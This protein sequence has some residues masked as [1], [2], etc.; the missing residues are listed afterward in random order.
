[1]YTEYNFNARKTERKFQRE[2]AKKGYFRTVKGFINKLVIYGKTHLT[3]Q[4]EKGTKPL[5]IARKSLR[6]AL[7]YVFFERTVIRKDM[8][9]YSKF[10]SALFA[11]VAHCFHDMSKLQVLKNGLYRLSLLGTR[12]FAS[13]LERDPETI[14]LLK[15]VNGNFVLFNYINI[16]ESPNCLKLLEEYN[17]YCLI[18]SGAFT[19]FNTKKKERE[20]VQLELLEDTELN[21][22]VLEGYAK[23]INE[24]KLNKRIL[25]F[26]PLDV[27]GDGKAT[28]ENYQKL[29]ALTD[30]HIIPVWQFT[31]SL[32]ELDHLVPEEHKIIA[33]GGL[34]PFVSNRKHIIRAVLDQVVAK[35]PKQCFHL[36]G[37]AN[38]L[39]L[40]YGV[41]SSDSTAFL[42][43]RKYE[44]GRKVYLSNGKRI[45]AHESMSTNEIIRKNLQFLVSLEN[46]TTQNQQLS[47][48]E[49]V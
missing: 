35:H 9:I 6:A 4:T 34:I 20:N 38:E 40:E 49:I 44:D 22:M 33:I 7:S 29:K 8:E 37:I 11:I 16:L 30:A 3:F 21:E 41:F 15:R 45:K 26:F 36:L 43:A 24:H 19:L 12:F 5:T 48:A 18:D 31:D 14:K 25:G 17:L 23:F 28:K 32:E 47:F 39:L 46:E 10:S 27:I 1:M 2:L 42:N 13:G